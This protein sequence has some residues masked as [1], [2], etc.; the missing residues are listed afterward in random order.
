[1]EKDE[2]LFKY[3]NGDFWNNPHEIKPQESEIKE[4]NKTRVRRI[5]RNYT[6]INQAH[7]WEPRH[8]QKIL[9]KGIELMNIPTG[10]KGTGRPSIPVSE[11][12]KICCTKSYHLK[13]GRN[14]V[15]YV[16]NARNNG[17]IFIPK[18]SENYFNR[19]NDYM[20][21][22]G[23]T[24][25][26]QQL[27]HITAEPFSK[28]DDCFA[29]DGTG[30]KTSS[31]K[32]RYLDIRTDRKKKREYVGLHIIAGVKSH[33][34]AH[35]IVS[36]GHVHD[37]NF[38]KPLIS[39]AR[40]IFNIKE[41]YADSAYLSKENSKFCQS[42]EIKDYTKPKENTVVKGLRNSP[43]A[44]SVQ[45][46]YEDLELKEYRRYPLRANVECTFDMLKSLFSD[47]LRHKKWDA[48]VNELLCRVICHN[49]RCLV[50]A[51][52][53]GHIEFPF[54]LY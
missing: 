9:N 19:I 41:V 51:Y 50:L 22:S 40:K 30:I 27:V 4:P 26:L 35:A 28:I 39:E 42:L 6:A 54:A 3:G 31:G 8:F 47:T 12:I 38:F 20:D 37:N 25:Y 23:L 44:K 21:D 5:T 24:Q 18:I 48:R 11:K 33:V 53:H 10:Y 49:I 45:R 36:K 46:Y 52:Y 15:Y 43:F 34:I 14:S 29:L 1:M 17:Y 13:G 16:E 32:R 7:Q 2:N